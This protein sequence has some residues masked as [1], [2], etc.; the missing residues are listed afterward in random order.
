MNDVVADSQLSLCFEITFS[1]LRSNF[2]CRELQNICHRF[3]DFFTGR[4]AY[5]REKD[6]IPFGTGAGPHQ[7]TRSSDIRGG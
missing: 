1:S 5:V 6:A 2:C 4:W 3:I 7:R